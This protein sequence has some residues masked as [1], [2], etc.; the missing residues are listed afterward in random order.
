MIKMIIMWKNK[1]F[2]NI[3]IDLKKKIKFIKYYNLI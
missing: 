2:Y 3:I 1:C